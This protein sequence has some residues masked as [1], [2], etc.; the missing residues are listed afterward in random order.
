MVAR[1]LSPEA[2]IVTSLNNPVGPELV[3]RALTEIAEPVE[4]L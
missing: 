1:Q 2:A 3:L 4:S